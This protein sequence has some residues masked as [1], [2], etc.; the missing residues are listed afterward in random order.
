[1]SDTE[2]TE[3][4]AAKGAPISSV[5]AL[6]TGS[7]PVDGGAYTFSKDEK[8]SFVAEEPESEKWFRPWIGG[9]ELLRGN[10]RYYLYLEEA[11]P[12]DLEKMPKSTERISQVEE[13]R[14][15]SQHPDIAAMA[16]RPAALVEHN[17]PDA[18][19]L[20]I[21]TFASERRSYVPMSV[22]DPGTFAGTTLYVMPEA[23][24]YELGVLESAAHMAWMRATADKTG[25]DYQYSP[26]RVYNT[27][28]WPTPTPEQK[29][30]IEETAQ[31]ILDTRAKFPDQ[32]LGTLYDDR[33]MPDELRKAHEAN[34]RAVMEA[35]GMDPDRAQEADVL[36]LLR[37]R[38]RELAGQHD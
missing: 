38:N 8:D 36:D 30:R 14:R 19:F 13:F 3:F 29:K 22:L 5:P 26:E 31:G 25:T 28:P 7:R 32:M 2:K 27:F 4:V 9:P 10:P 33:H 12:E 23:S 35:Y 24:L 37:I 17:M 18:P 6:I 21:P 11:T 1:M 34:D 16:D 20:V 15:S